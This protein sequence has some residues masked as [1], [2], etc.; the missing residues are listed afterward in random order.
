MRSRRFA[1]RELVQERPL[2]IQLGPAY[3]LVGDG[4][5]VTAARELAERFGVGPTRVC[6]FLRRSIR[7]ALNGKIG[8]ITA[9]GAH[10]S[11]RCRSNR[12]Q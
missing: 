12:H 7:T 8:R 9:Y 11:A 4:K 3:R 6:G 2:S 10:L 5:Q 1:S